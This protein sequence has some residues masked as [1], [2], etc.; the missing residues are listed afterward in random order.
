MCKCVTYKL[1]L[2][3]DILPNFFTCIKKMDKVNGDGCWESKCAKREFVLLRRVD[4]F[5][6]PWVNELFDM[7]KGQ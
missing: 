5:P 4:T 3:K 2:L 7:K 1:F 6:I